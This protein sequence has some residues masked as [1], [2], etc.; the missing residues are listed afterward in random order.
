VG[1]YQRSYFQAGFMS[2]AA[3]VCNNLEMARV[4]LGLIHTPEL[5]RITDAYPNTVNSW[6]QEGAGSFNN[7]VMTGGIDPACRYAQKFVR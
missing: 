7:L 3:K 6:V 5:G 4:A 2:R 1:R